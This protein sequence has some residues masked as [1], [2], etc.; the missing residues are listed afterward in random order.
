MVTTLKKNA[1]KEFIDKLWEKLS[2]AKR[3]KG[4]K[5]LAYCGKIKLQIDPLEMQKKLRDEWD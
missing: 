3:S 4:V 2:T 5:T 1:S